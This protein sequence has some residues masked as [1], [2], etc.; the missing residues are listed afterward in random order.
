MTSEFNDPAWQAGWVR[1]IAE[2]LPGMVCLCHQGAIS[3]LN[4]AGLALLGA[5]EGRPVEAGF[6]KG[7]SGLLAVA[8]LPARGLLEVA[9]ADGRA[10]EMRAQIFA[11][12][13]DR[14]T[15][16]VVAQPSGEAQDELVYRRLVDLSH[17]CMCI[18]HNGVISFINSAGLRLL[19]ATQ[20]EAVVGHNFAEFVHHDYVDVLSGGLAPLCDER[21]AVPLKIVSLTNRT[22]DV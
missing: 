4:P 22:S 18:C 21:E 19:G 15:L 7:Q 3:Y 6:P 13:E 1:H 10:L 9:A 17:E 16:L 20:A 5:V 8:E 12:S 14:T 11:L 2:R